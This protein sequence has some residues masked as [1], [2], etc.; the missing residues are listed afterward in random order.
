MVDTPEKT[1]ND[2]KEDPV[3]DNPPERQPKRQLPRCRSK[4]RHSKDCSTGTG[5]NNTPDDAKNNEDPVKVTSEQGNGKMGKLALMNRPYTETR[6][7]III[8]RSPRRRRALATRISSCLRN[9]SSR[10]ALNAG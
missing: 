3:E 7:T 4:S 1:N 5:E 6:R 9:L 10:S 8:F 2:D